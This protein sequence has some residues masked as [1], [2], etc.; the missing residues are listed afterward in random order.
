MARDREDVNC[1]AGA[2]TELTNA[3]ATNITFIVKDGDD[4]RIQ[5]M[6][7]STEPT[8]TTEGIPYQNGQGEAN[9]ALSKLWGSS[10]VRVFVYSEDGNV[11]YVDH[12]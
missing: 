6:S 12:A 7:S 2:W 11:I 9:I 8:T 5:G 4:V 10:A 3:N 1:A